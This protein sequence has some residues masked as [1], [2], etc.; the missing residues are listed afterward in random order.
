MLLALSL[1][2]LLF[3][4]AMPIYDYRVQSDILVFRRLYKLI[5]V[6]SLT[7]SSQM[8]KTTVAP[9]RYKDWHLLSLK[10]YQNCESKF[11]L[12]FFGQAKKTLKN[13]FLQHSLFF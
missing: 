11:E 5:F 3:K 8:C 9:S 6:N 4:A 12:L 7:L 13:V 1:N 2:T 10:T